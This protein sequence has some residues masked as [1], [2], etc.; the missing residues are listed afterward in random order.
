MRPPLAKV[1]SHLAPKSFHPG[2]SP[3]YSRTR[4]II[5]EECLFGLWL[6]ERGILQFEARLF[7]FMV[8]RTRN[9]TFEVR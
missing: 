4:N 7:W 3:S 8:Y 9:I 2:Y 6:K 1:T 5:F